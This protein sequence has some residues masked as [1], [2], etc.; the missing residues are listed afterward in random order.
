MRIGI[1]LGDQYESDPIGELAAR[2]ATA[3]ADGFASAWLPQIFSVDAPTAFAA[4]AAATTSIELG[5]GVLPTY[6]RHPLMLAAQARTTQ[7]AV[8]GRFVLGIGLSHRIVVESMLGMSYDKPA[9]HMRE[10]LSVLGPL[11]R[12]E[13]VSFEGEVFRVNASLNIPA[14]PVP[15]LVAALGARMLETAG[16]LADGTI[17][18]MTGPATVRDHIV[19]SIRRAAEAAGRP[20]P[21]VVCCLPVMVTDDPDAAR[22]RAAQVFQVYGHLP[23]YRA[24]LDREGASGPADV[25]IV[26]DEATVRARIEAVA[27]TGATDF[28][29]VEFA[30]A[31]AQQRT[32]S[33]LK[34]LL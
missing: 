15:V 5:T 33:L 28:V 30:P 2:L 16:R 20:A 31:E 27:E 4:T 32:R 13:P 22:E 29:A 7:A 25:A 9:R 26:G 19:P 14:A 8:H 34:T 18:W 3:E 21:R 6:P 11:L 1:F 23:A 12:G 24:M 17:T 10:Y